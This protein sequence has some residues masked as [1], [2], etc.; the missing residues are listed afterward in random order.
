MGRVRVWRSTGETLLIKRAIWA[1]WWADP[2]PS[3]MRALARRLGV[4]LS[5][6]QRV[7]RKAPTEGMDSLLCQPVPTQA[8]LDRERAVTERLR[9]S[10]PDVFQPHP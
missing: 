5:Y 1:W 6:V 4:R 9:R 3:S 10:A 7:L 2:R 8:D